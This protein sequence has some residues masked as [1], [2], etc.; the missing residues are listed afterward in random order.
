VFGTTGLVVSSNQ[1]WD[2][3]GSPSGAAITLNNTGG[4]VAHCTVVGNSTLNYATVLTNPAGCT[5]AGNV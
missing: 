2:G 1:I 5:T 3:G 4:G